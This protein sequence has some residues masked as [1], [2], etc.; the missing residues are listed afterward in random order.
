VIPNMSAFGGWGGFLGVRPV[1][2]PRAQLP[3]ATLRQA[4]QRFPDTYSLDHAEFVRGPS[5]DSGPLLQRTSNTALNGTVALI[6]GGIANL[7]AAYELS[8]CGVQVTLFEKRKAGPKLQDKPFGGR[9]ITQDLHGLTAHL[10]AEAFAGRSPLFWHYVWRVGLANGIPNPKIGGVPCSRYGSPGVVP[11]KICYQNQWFDFTTDLL[12]LPP[13]VQEAALLFKEWLLSLNDGGPEP[14]TVFLETAMAAAKAP[15]TQHG[16]GFFWQEMRRRYDGRSFESVLMSEVFAAAS[17]PA[18]VLAA[19]AAVG[20]GTG[21][22]G[23][24]YDVACLEI[25]RQVVWDAEDFYQL[26]DLKPASGQEQEDEQATGVQGYDLA[27][28]TQDFAVAALKVSQGFFPNRTFDD[29]FRFDSS[30][31]TLCVVDSG[32]RTRIGVCLAGKQPDPFDLA[33]V[34]V[35]SRAMEA[36]G[37]GQNRVANPFTT[38]GLHTPTSSVAVRSVQAAIHRLNMVSSYKHFAR[39]PAPETVPAWP[40]DGT[41]RPITCFV[42]DRYARLTYLPPGAGVPKETLAVSEVWGADVHTLQAGDAALRRTKLASTFDPPDAGPWPYQAVADALGRASEHAGIDWNK[43]AGFGGGI[44]LDR[45]EDEYFAASL[46]CQS[47]LALELGSENAPWGRVFLAGD[48]VG[49]L[50]G[51]VEGTAQSAL[52]ATT[53]VLYQIRKLNPNIGLS[54]LR[55]EELIRP[56]RDK[57]H[58]WRT[59]STKVS[60]LPRVKA[61]TAVADFS[62]D[63]QMPT[64]WRRESVPAGGPIERMAVSPDGQSFAAVSYGTPMWRAY[65]VDIHKWSDWYVVAPPGGALGSY[66]GRLA[67]SSTADNIRIIATDDGLCYCGD[68]VTG[69]TRWDQVPIG[70]DVTAN[71]ATTAVALTPQSPVSTHLAVV[72]TSDS[73]LLYGVLSPGGVWSSFAEVP[74]A[75]PR[76]VMKVARVCLDGTTRSMGV[77]VVVIDVTGGIQACGRLAD[78]TFTGWTDIV[79]PQRGLTAQLMATASVGAM[80]RVVAKFSDGQLYETRLRILPLGYQQQWRPLPYPASA[81]YDTTE[82]VMGESVHLGDP[83]GSSTLWVASEPATAT[84]TDQRGDVG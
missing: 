23:P 43:S 32:Q 61:W 35:S 36:M 18:A 8:R 51:S 52:T 20:L 57:A 22:F 84:D 78:G 48:S 3:L 50:G 71:S 17:Q 79:P 21:G 45:P 11:T 39:I 37:L 56:Q 10:G 4:A 76:G 46:L 53:A 13:I 60:A 42:T 25:L 33:I 73:A 70:V 19:F 54:T 31:E 69:F 5:F 62:V 12:K 55:S 27:G 38:D 29:M 41:G 80:T 72:R 26:P 44:K 58:S 47:E 83:T 6:G 2:T 9:L 75:Q 30:V 49:Y 77:V 68:S 64:T 40:V 74:R 15:S 7:I 81:A 14:S 1:P 59:I 63:K 28:F 34:A 65:S 24:V 82:L 16:L 66:G 67:I